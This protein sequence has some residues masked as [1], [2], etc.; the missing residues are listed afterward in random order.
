MD[1]GGC[2]GLEPVE[3]YGDLRESP[4]VSSAAASRRGSSRLLALIA[5]AW[6]SPPRFMPV[7]GDVPQ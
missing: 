3:E 4:D 2:E 5:T 1:E 6:R 7:D